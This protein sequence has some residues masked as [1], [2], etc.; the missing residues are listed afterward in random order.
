MWNCPRGCQSWDIIIPFDDCGNC[1]SEFVD[2]NG[3]TFD[4]LSS[5]DQEIL[6]E[7]RKSKEG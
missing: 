2:E 4:E 6:H 7:R 3:K 5:K 1:G